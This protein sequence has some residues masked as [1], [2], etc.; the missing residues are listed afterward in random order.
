MD[1]ILKGKIRK[2]DKSQQN[3][4]KNI[5]NEQFKIKSILADL[6][7][8]KSILF[9]MVL[10]FLLLILIPATTIC[11]ITTTTARNDLLKSMEDSVVAATL[12]NSNY[13]DSFLNNA[14]EMS[15][16]IRTNQ[17]LQVF[18]QKNAG[19]ADENAKKDASAALGL[20]N[21]STADL[22]VKILYN[23]GM[24]L[25][26]MRAPADMS[27]VM[28]TA[29]Y[30]KVLDA[31]GEPV[32][33]DYSEAMDNTKFR[34]YAVSLVSLYQNPDTKENIGLVI[35]DVDYSRVDSAL[36]SIKLGK[37]DSSYLI[38]PE[39]KV[40][41]AQGQGEE[42][43]LKNRDFVKAV[44]E[45]SAIKDKDCFYAKDNG[46]DYLISYY[47]S[48]DT[49]LA[50]V[51]IVPKEKI[52][53]GADQ[54]MSST[55]KVGIIF[56]VLA[57]I[58][59]FIFSLGMSLALKSIMSVMQKAENG[60]LTGTIS[61]KRKDEF[62]RLASSF[63]DMLLNIRN[64]IAQNNKAAGEVVASSEKMAL[65][66]SQTSHISN[67][68]AHAIIEVASGSSNQASEI[69][70]SVKNVSLLADKI[71][72]AVE[73]THVM[74]VD[75]ETMIELSDY[76]LTTIESLNRKTVQTNEITTNVV[77]EISQL[78]QYV[79]NI[80]V[81]TQV[82]RSIADQTNL[83]ALNAAIEAARAG[84]AGKGF[85]VVADEIRKLA[86]QSNNHTREIQKHIEN[87]FKQAQS[88]TQLVGKAEA[89]IREQS[90]M[91]TQTADVFSR[92]NATTA[93]L[94]QNITNVGNMI[95]DMDANKEMVLSSME[96][97]SAVSEQV[98]ASTQEVSA[99]TQEQ[100]ALIE[101]LD[102]MSRKLSDLAANLIEQMAKFKV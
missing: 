78:N 86:E 96:N 88:S 44:K 12:Q 19:I 45:H 100:L 23:S 32:W 99:S 37:R 63:N 13:F 30:K 56:V 43:T 1:S 5:G 31:G 81:I 51:T 89:S 29:W 54:I 39:G 16:Q 35:V 61:I 85:A 41:S 77:K 98:S 46:M 26:S 80:N 101:Q 87:V 10:V 28:A 14:I 66:S 20:I 79:K 7:S 72:L 53:A 74:E 60:D 57:G 68:I 83:L 24:V 102:G 48:P 91:V 58:F 64:L 34:N 9:K 65:I 40:M 27:K 6:T 92:I 25:G 42:E 11:Y 84:D 71:S 2:E 38:T 95:T 22:N 15:A 67:E 97:I 90:E 82:L 94:A 3:R 70:I 17:V 75:S 50:A 52:T 49:D 21:S 33:V 73:K 69:E 8:P 36:A 4:H 47:K 76:G 55:I 93:I 18:S 59:G 62:S